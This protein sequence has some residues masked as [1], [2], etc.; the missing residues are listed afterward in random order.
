MFAVRSIPNSEHP[1]R[2]V[3]DGQVDL[4]L[5]DGSVTT[6]SKGDVVVQRGTAHAWHNRSSG[7]VR[8]LFINVDGD[9]TAEMKS[10]LGDDALS[11]LYE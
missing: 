5:D 4:E 3:L 7:T 10:T 2:V 11:E 1:K 9:F 6:M 8:L